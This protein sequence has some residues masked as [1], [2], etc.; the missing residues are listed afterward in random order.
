MI[1]IPAWKLLIRNLPFYIEVMG[2]NKNLKDLKNDL[3]IES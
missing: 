1:L 2:Y 3:N